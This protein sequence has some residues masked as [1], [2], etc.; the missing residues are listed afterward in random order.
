MVLGL[1]LL[2]EPLMRKKIN[3]LGSISPYPKIQRSLVLRRFSVHCLNNERSECSF[4]E[5][6][7]EL[8]SAGR[9]YQHG[10]PHRWPR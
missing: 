8:V 7:S 3:N 10:E 9:P 2:I 1:T 4:G 5:T 6:S